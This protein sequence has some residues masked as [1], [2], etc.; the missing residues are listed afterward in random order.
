VIFLAT[1]FANNGD[2]YCRRFEAMCEKAG[3]RHVA[4][5]PAFTEIAST[6]QAK[7]ADGR[8][9]SHYGPKGTA[10]YAEALTPAIEA[11]LREQGVM[12]RGEVVEGD[13]I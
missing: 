8:Y 9:D 7:L 10:T 1:A 5:Y 4:I 13:A 6:Y 11:A 12:A 2:G 3:V